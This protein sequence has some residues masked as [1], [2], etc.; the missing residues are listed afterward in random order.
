MFHSGQ[1]V[2]KVYLKIKM[3]SI[4]SP[5][6]TA[7]LSMVLN[8]TISWRRRFGKNLTSFIILRRRNVLKTESPEPSSVTPYIN[9]E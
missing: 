9:P 3:K 5:K 7:T 1:L 8:I 4:R 2:K 6:N